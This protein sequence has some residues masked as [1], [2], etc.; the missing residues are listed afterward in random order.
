VGTD[1]RVGTHSIGL[2]FAHLQTREVLVTISFPKSQSYT[3]KPCLEKPNQTKPNQTKPN[4]TKPN[5]TKPNQ[6]KPNK[7]QSV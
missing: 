2:I 1:L 7:N 6:T 4:Q 3:E 5:Q